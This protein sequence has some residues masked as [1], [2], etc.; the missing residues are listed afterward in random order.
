MSNHDQTRKTEAEVWFGNLISR[1]HGEGLE[2]L[3]A[4]LL[5]HETEIL[6]AYNDKDAGG[7][8]ARRVSPFLYT[9]R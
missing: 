7:H 3:A 5:Q 9:L 6:A 2:E 4:Y 1:A 8:G